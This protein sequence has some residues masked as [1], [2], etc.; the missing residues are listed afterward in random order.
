MDNETNTILNR[1]LNFKSLVESEGW[2][3]MI[4]VKDEMVKKLMDI[5]QM[6]T[7]LSNEDFIKEIQ[8]RQSSVALLEE[9][10]K[11]TTGQAEMYK[12][13][14]CIAKEIEDNI[15]VIRG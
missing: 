11:V 3:Q 15:I 9:L 4:E 8:L 5:R 2:L 14:C 7:G 1:Q 6:P 12:T 10:I 13:N